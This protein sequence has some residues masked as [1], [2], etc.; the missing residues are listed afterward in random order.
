MSACFPFAGGVQIDI[1]DGRAVITDV[2][3][4]I[5]MGWVAA[6]AE[7]IINHITNAKGEK[8]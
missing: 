8:S 5:F 6:A 2:S 1:C 3:N 7:R 4:S